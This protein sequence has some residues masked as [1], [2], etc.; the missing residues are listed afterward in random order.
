MI[1]LSEAEREMVETIVKLYATDQHYTVYVF[2]SRATG[3]SRKYSDIDLALIG[4]HSVSPKVSSE[5]AEAF[6]ESSIPYTVDIVDGTKASER[7]LQQ[8]LLE[9][10]MLIQI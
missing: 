5:L 8:I 9:G 6:D 3:K 10:E 7:L 2:G 1:A 4:E